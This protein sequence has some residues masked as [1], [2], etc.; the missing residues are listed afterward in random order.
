MVCD[1]YYSGPVLMPEMCPR[2]PS[3]AI[4]AGEWR[5][6][7]IAV[8]VEV[9]VEELHVD[10]DDDNNNGNEQSISDRRGSE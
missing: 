4:L 2:S 10:D 8:L 6:P 7:A 1:C 5:G 9:E 3:D